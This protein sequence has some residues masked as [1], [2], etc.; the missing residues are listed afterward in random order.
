MYLKDDTP[1]NDDTSGES[2]RKSHLI[3]SGRIRSRGE[4]SRQTSSTLSRTSKKLS[5]ENKLVDTQ[6]RESTSSEMMTPSSGPTCEKEES[7]QRDET[8]D[9]R[10]LYERFIVGQAHMEDLN[11]SLWET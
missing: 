1:T 6:H 8:V 2:G 11:R 10:S 4:K 7:H 5:T 3:G 9:Y